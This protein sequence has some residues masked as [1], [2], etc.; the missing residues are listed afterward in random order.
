MGLE[1]LSPDAPWLELDEHTA[2]RIARKRT[3]LARERDQTLRTLPGSEEAAAEARQQV[4]AERLRELGHLSPAGEDLSPLEAAALQVAEDLCVMERI[5][6]AWRLTAACVCFPTRWDLPSKMGLSLSDVHGAV[7]GYAGA[8]AASADRFFDRMKPDRIFER[9][10]WSLLDDPELYQPVAVRGG[11][12]DQGLTAAD[13]GQRVWIRVERQTLRRLPRTG[14]VLFTIGIHQD[15]LSSI[16]GRPET[17][18]AL[19]GSIR[20]MPPDFAAYKALEP[21]R[22]AVLAYAEAV[23]AER[24]PRGP[25]RAC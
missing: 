12:R 11:R 14:A 9:R 20:S 10:N 16:D 6:A 15:R 22:E 21:I 8:L 17:A 7:P 13:A 25:E 4:E 1:A 2:E 18:A 3:L 24:S 19:A 23:G 5:G